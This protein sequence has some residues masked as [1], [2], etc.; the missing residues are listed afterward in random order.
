ML[1]AAVGGLLAQTMSRTSRPLRAAVT[2]VELPFS[3]SL[4]V[5]EKVPQLAGCQLHGSQPTRLHGN[6]GDELGEV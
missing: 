3:H 4:I 2:W 6:C 5:S 1:A